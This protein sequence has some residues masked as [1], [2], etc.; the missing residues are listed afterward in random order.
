MAGSYKVWSVS[1][2]A[3]VLIGF[4]GCGGPSTPPA[5]IQAGGSEGE[6][7]PV[8]NPGETPV[9]GPPASAPEG[10][11]PTPIAP[12]QQDLHPK[13]RIKTNH[14]TIVVK[15]D[16]ENAPI[17][18]ENFLGN[19]VDTGFYSDTLVHY[20]QKGTMLIAGGIN[21]SRQPKVT[22]SPIFNEAL[23]TGANRRGTIAMSRDPGDAHSATSQFFFNLTDNPALDHK[24]VETPEDYGYSVFGEVVEGL[25]VLDK[26][27][28]VAVHEAGGFPNTPVEPVVIQAV[29]RMK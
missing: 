2:I 15:L 5:N 28:G 19:Y 20:V 11:F 24:G 26:I 1:S 8:T 3:L 25:D 23:R 6:T 12:V 10:V 22:K 29:E 4:A 17:T 9:A 7:A 14:G 18:V 27:G 13:V 21:A 16:R